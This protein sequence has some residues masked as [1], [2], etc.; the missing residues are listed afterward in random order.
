MARGLSLLLALF[1]FWLLLSGHYTSLL[2]TI[3]LAC[4]I[5]VAL[6]TARIHVLDLEGHPIGFLVGAVTYWPWLAWEIVKSALDVTKEILRPH[7]AITPTMVRVDASQRTSIGF[8]T[9]ANSITLTPGTISTTVSF[10]E[11]TIL[12]H[13]LTKEGAES[14]AEGTMNRRV[15]RF[16]GSR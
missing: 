5:L 8:A 11:R 12:V 9:Y 6:F 3:G 10:D 2:V 13:A 15:T 1:A 14:T 7:L 4:A 16:E